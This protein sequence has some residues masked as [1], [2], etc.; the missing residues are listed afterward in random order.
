M[1]RT[2]G[3]DS[4]KSMQNPSLHLIPVRTS[5]KNLPAA[6]LDVVDRRALSRWLRSLWQPDG[7]FVMHVGGEVDIRGVYCALSVARL[8]GVYSDDMFRGTELWVARWVVLVQI[9]Q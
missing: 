4:N 6:A 3:T 1:G 8:T 9:A 2:N 5:H 7:S